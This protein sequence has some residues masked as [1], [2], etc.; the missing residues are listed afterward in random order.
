V[1]LR[2]FL[3]L[4]PLIVTG[5][6][7]TVAAAQE[8]ASTPRETEQ[9]GQ[10]ARSSGEGGRDLAGYRFPALAA[11]VAA[12]QNMAHAMILRDYCANAGL[13][14]EFVRERLARFSRMTGRE[15][16]CRSLLDY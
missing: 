2:A 12:A 1:S 11:T 5:L 3:I 14:A 9:A 10:A 16:T 15:E 7:H 13:P 6:V 8:T 4:A